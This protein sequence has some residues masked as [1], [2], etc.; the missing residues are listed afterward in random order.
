MDTSPVNCVCEMWRRYFN[1]KLTKSENQRKSNGL[2]FSGRTL[3]LFIIL[4]ILDFSVAQDMRIL[5]VDKYIDSKDGNSS[6]N[7]IKQE[8]PVSLLWGIA[9]TS[10]VVGRL[11]KHHIPSDAFKGNIHKYVVSR[12][13]L[14]Y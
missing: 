11:F 4:I 7:Q 3:G 6:P 5:N 1:G 8:E 9:D 12:Q 13:K 2:F 14:E 10:A